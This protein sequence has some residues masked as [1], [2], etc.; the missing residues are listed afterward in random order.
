MN[1]KDIQRILELLGNITEGKW[2]IGHINDD[3]G[4]MDVIS[5][6]QG[7]IIAE[8][9]AE[10][11]ALAIVELP[12]MVE[13]IKQQ[14]EG[15]KTYRDV[16]IVD[17]VIAEKQQAKLDKAIEALEEIVNGDGY[18]CSRTRAQQALKELK[19]AKLDSAV[20]AACPHIKEWRLER[21]GWTEDDPPQ[22]INHT[23]KKCP[24]IDEDGCQAM[25]RGIAEEIVIPALKAAEES[26]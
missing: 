10:H 4:F 26:Q 23:C 24:H 17:S 19:D 5:T 20:W 25:C 11:N 7:E 9:V 2:G 14:Q 13:I 1:D 21:L 16:H 12:E 8:D 6:Y 22:R 15:L 3:F 18:T